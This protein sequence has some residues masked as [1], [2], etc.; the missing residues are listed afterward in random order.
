MDASAHRLHT[1]GVTDNAGDAPV[2]VVANVANAEQL[3]L[4]RLFGINLP[5]TNNEQVGPEISGRIFRIVRNVYASMDEAGLADQI[6][7]NVREAQRM[8]LA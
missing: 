2:S 8:V 5:T 4:N 3:A 1:I 7:A 6:S